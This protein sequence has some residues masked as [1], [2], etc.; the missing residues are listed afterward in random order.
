MIRVL[1]G[2][3]GSGKTK[4]LLDWVNE[5]VSSENGNVVCIERGNRL[6][7]DVD[8]R[9]RLIEADEFKISDFNVFYGFLCG[10]ISGNFDITHIFIDSILKIAKGSISDFDK[11]IPK[12][13]ELSEKFGVKFS[14]A[15]SAPIEEKTPA[16]EKY[17]K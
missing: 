2:L 10:I 8:K 4:T 1:M 5:A 9:V 17:L 15:I 6:M 12:L 14:I 13:E 3:K 7:F 11:F 16:I